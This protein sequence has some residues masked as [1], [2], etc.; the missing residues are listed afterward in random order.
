MFSLGSYGPHSQ[1]ASQE[2]WPVD[3]K[4]IS[5][6]DKWLT[7]LTVW[8]A[9]CPSAVPLFPTVLCVRGKP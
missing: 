8:C 1:N 4:E 3:R 5:V 9:L 2:Q 6:P 7:N